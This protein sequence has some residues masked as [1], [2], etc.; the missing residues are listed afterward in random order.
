MKVEFEF[1]VYG[2]YKL[3]M[4]YKMTVQH[5]KRY[6][7]T[8]KI[9]HKENIVPNISGD[10]VEIFIFFVMGI[11]IGEIHPPDGTKGKVIIEEME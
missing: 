11:L 3:T 10:M 5:D 1:K 8:A 2:G 9:E 6:N 4:S 7:I